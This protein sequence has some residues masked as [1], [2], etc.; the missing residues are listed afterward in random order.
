MQGRQLQ[1]TKVGLIRTTLQFDSFR[2]ALY[3]E[4]PHQ[5]IVNVTCKMKKETDNT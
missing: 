2:A 3:Q 4:V 5:L 1:L